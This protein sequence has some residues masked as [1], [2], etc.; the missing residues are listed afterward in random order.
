MRQNKALKKLRQKCFTFHKTRLWRNWEKTFKFGSLAPSKCAAW[1]VNLVYIAL[2][3]EWQPELD[4]KLLFCIR[5]FVFK[6]QMR[7]LVFVYL[8]AKYKWDFSNLYINLQNTNA[9]SCICIFVCKIQMRFLYLYTKTN[10]FCVTW[11]TWRPPTSTR[12]KPWFEGSYRFKFNLVT[13]CT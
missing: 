5:V 6:I 9:I 13:G 11:M 1:E 8:Y 4:C 2:D 7:L 12:L 10:V 3:E